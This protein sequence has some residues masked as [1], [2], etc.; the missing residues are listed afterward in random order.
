[1]G[2][3]NLYG[4]E[5]RGDTLNFLPENLKVISDPKHPLYDPRVER[6]PSEEMILSIMRQGVLVPLSVHRDGEDGIVNDG[7]QGRAATSGANR[8]L[9]KEGGEPVLCPC[10]W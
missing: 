4:A 3:K 1:M 8:R 6:E 10:V 2:T 5:G 7:R 9:K